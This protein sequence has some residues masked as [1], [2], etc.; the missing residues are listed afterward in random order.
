[1]PKGT[2]SL[3]VLAEC[4]LNTVVMYQ[5]H[6]QFISQEISDIVALIAKLII[7][8]PTEEQKQNPDLKEVI[9]DFVTVQVRSLSFVVY[10][11]A[12]KDILNANADLLVEGILQLFQNCPAEL[13][14]IRKD[15]LAISRHIISD[16]RSSKSS[17]HSLDP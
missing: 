3:K 17:L 5:L 11:K 1:M 4:A 9:A 12:N 6:K 16:L 8:K 13:V 10:F 14:S 2:R 7:I 15:L